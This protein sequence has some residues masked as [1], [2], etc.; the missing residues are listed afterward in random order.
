MPL[1]MEGWGAVLSLESPGRSLALLVDLFVLLPLK[2]AGGGR[3]ELK[4][5]S[6]WQS[7]KAQSTKIVRKMS[8]YCPTGW[9]SDVTLG[10]HG[11][12]K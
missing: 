1:G 2:A 5:W 10:L 9:K 6:A 7:P 3:G 4:M 8:V 12:C 11:T